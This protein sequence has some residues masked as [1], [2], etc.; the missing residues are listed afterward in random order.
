MTKKEVVICNFTMFYGDNPG[1][2]LL[3]PETSKGT[4]RELF[5]RPLFC[6]TLCVVLQLLFPHC[7]VA[8]LVMTVQNSDNEKS[9]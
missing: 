8:D 3:P 4:R 7:V 1:L 9:T 2:I 5:L 6:E